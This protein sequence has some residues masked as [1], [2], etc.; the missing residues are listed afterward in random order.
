MTKI[1]CGS[2]V[3]VARLDKS[4]GLYY[5]NILIHISNIFVAVATPAPQGAVTLHCSTLHKRNEENVSKT[6][7]HKQSAQKEPHEP[8]QDPVSAGAVHPGAPRF[9]QGPLV[10]PRGP[11][12]HPGPPVSPRGP[13]FHPGAPLVSPSHFKNALNLSWGQR[14]CD[15][16]AEPDLNSD[17]LLKI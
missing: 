10:S 3:H 1:L 13:P 8:L 12:F 4:V 14:S 16:R 2:F 15:P 11:P 5:I 7:K 17:F 9:T 6:E